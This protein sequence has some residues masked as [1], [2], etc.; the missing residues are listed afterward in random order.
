MWICC[1]S[2]RKKDREGEGF[3]TKNFGFLSQFWFQI[4]VLVLTNLVWPSCLTT[5]NLSFNICENRSI[6]DGFLL[7]VSMRLKWS[8][9]SIAQG[10][11]RGAGGEEDTFSQLTPHP[12]P[13]ASLLLTQSH[14][15]ILAFCRLL[16]LRNLKINLNYGGFSA[17]GALAGTSV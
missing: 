17:W 11:G 9:I 7:Q 14:E 10:R 8:R 1:G 6:L 3:S 15:P 5:Q 4:Q 12:H 13:P 16:Q 2:K